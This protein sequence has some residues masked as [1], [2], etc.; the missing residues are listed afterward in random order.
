MFR[1]F[2]TLCLPLLWA[3][4][5]TDQE[6]PTAVS[7]DQPAFA[8]ADAGS[9]GTA[10]HFQ[11][12]APIVSSPTITGTFDAG[13]S[14]V[15][16]VH[17]CTTPVSCPT[18]VATFDR[19]SGVTVD[20]TAGSYSAVW[21]AA[22]RSLDVGQR[23]RVVVEEGGTPLGYADVQIVRNT[24]SLA[25]VPS[26][27]VGV[28]IGKT[29]AINFHIAKPTQYLVTSSSTSPAAGSTVTIT[30]QLA[31]ENGNRVPESGR[32]VT[33]SST[34]GGSFSS[35]TSTTDAGGV[36]TVAFTTSTTAGVTH[37]VTAT[38][39][40]GL[41]GTSGNLV[42]QVG[43]ADMEASTITPRS[44]RVNIERSDT[45]TVTVQL[46]DAYGNNLTTRAG[47]VR[48]STD[49]GTFT[50]S[51]G[52]SGKT[53][54]AI[55][56]GDGRYTAVYTGAF[57]A[58]ATAYEV[59]TIRATLDGVALQSTAKIELFRSTGSGCHSCYY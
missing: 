11:W 37:T 6:G 36:A 13:R 56:R 5:C 45:T 38:D 32:T 41:T 4:G 10:T 28:V 8:I 12:L 16:K 59:A 58:G 25:T 21:E 30:V 14:P 33:W 18:P 35:S 53:V 9:D 23:L 51:D 44:T 52:S 17:P 40:Q 55:C 50:G 19:Q 2:L 29:L 26:G 3:A 48:L 27:F 22:R 1:R 42:T 43:P 15:V 57:S 7:P 24:K 34:N 31:D 49:V 46:R 39:G 20:A 47:T 54:T